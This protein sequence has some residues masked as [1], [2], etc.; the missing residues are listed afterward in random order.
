[1]GIGVHPVDQRYEKEARRARP[2]QV[3]ILVV[4]F[5]F[6]LSHSLPKRYI[7]GADVVHNLYLGMW[8]HYF[9]SS[10]SKIIICVSK[11]STKSNILTRNWSRTRKWLRNRRDW[12][13]ME[14][15]AAVG[16]GM[17]N[18]CE[19]LTNTWQPGESSLSTGSK[20]TCV[21]RFLLC[22]DHTDV[23][24]I[25]KTLVALSM[26]WIV[27][28]LTWNLSYF[29]GFRNKD[30]AFFHPASK[31]LIEADLL[32]NLPATE[33][34]SKTGL[35]G[36]FPILGSI[37]PSTWLQKQASWLLG[38]DKECVFSCELLQSGRTDDRFVTGQWFV[39]W[40]Q[41]LA[42]TSNELF[43]VMGCVTFLRCL[44]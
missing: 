5:R 40:R 14:V 39:T 27:L 1:M 43:L 28:D 31:S 3:R 26:Q 32:F 30:V 2:R 6:E 19:S 12:S 4:V 35:S 24:N 8:T 16:I 25:D 9:R 42:G 41:L 13:L 11:E 37:N 29:S 21:S 7:V 20:T 38:V 17:N 33:Q 10:M 34:Y 23:P 18:M 15:R 22:T 44:W 36:N